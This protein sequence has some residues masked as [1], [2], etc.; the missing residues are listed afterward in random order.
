LKDTGLFFCSKIISKHFNS[1]LAEKFSKKFSKITPDW[2]FSVPT[3]KVGGIETSSNL[4]N[5]ISSIPVYIRLDGA[6]M[7]L[8]R[9][10]VFYSERSTEI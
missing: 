10:P 4:E 2:Q 7:I 9:R 3:R 6:T 5:R 8:A 1:A